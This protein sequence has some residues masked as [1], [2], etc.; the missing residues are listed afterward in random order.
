MTICKYCLSS[1]IHILSKA[2]DDIV[3]KEPQNPVGTKRLF[4]HD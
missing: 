3:I 4:S 1:I 2:K